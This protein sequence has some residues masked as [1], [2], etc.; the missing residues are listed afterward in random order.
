MNN[1]VK[2]I[3]ILSLACVLGLTSISIQSCKD[4]DKPPV[5]TNDDDNTSPDPLAGKDYLIFEGVKVE[6]RNPEMGKMTT[7][8]LDTVLEWYGNKPSG[9]V[10]DTVLI[11]SHPSKDE[12]IESKPRAEGIYTFVPWPGNVSSTNT[13][14]TRLRWG[15]L[16]GRPVVDLT[17]GTYELKRV[18][19]KWVSILKNGTGTWTKSNGDK[20]NYTGIEFKA[21]WPN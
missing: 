18:D 20:V 16:S 19:G 17:G 6:F 11:I 4:D 5:I 13:V 2:F 9:T 14:T 10:G 12:D 8:D 7:S 21:T 1:K 3:Q 15:T